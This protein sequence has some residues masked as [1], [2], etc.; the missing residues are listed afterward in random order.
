LCRHGGR[1]L[2]ATETGGFGD[3]AGASA[4]GSAT[5]RSCANASL[6]SHQRELRGT[7]SGICL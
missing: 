4:D 7:L 5:S 2:S 6:R 3:F 1:V